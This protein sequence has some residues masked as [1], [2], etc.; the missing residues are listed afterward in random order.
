MA[1]L[2]QIYMARVSVRCSSVCISQFE[3]Y[4][5]TINACVCCVLC[6]VCCYINRYIIPIILIMHLHCG[7]VFS[8]VSQAQRHH[9]NE[10]S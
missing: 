8:L 2:A 4:F 7:F 5:E 6:A 1:A 3:I 10:F 9:F